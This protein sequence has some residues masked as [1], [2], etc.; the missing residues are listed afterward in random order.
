[1]LAAEAIEAFSKLMPGEDFADRAEAVMRQHGEVVELTPL[2]TFT[3]GLYT[4]TLVVGAGQMA[5]SKIHNTRH[6][7]VIVQGCISVWTKETGVVTLHAPFHGVTEPG[8]QRVVLAHTDTCWMT[9]HPTDE[10]DLA[11]I[12]DQ[13][14]MKHDNP[15]LEGGQP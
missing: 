15:Y 1:M 14:I 10:T 4:R 11:V 7:F 5:V 6:Q 8:T 9:F 13:L 12:E 2:H 3:P